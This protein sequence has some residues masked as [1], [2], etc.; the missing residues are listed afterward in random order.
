MLSAPRNSLALLILKTVEKGF[1][2][3]F[4]FGIF[5]S[6]SDPIEEVEGK[7]DK[8]LR[9]LRSEFTQ[10]SSLSGSA[11]RLERTS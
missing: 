6:G 5:S 1:C 3:K 11:Q 7:A 4:F 8:A 10:F 9:A 2:F